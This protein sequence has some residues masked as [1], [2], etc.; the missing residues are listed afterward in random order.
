M[1]TDWFRTEFAAGALDDNEQRMKAPYDPNQPIETLYTQL[2]H[3]IGFADVAATPYTPNQIVTTSYNLVFKTGLYNDTCRE[4]RRRPTADKTWAH[5]QAEF[6]LLPKICENH[7]LP[8]NPRAI[9]ALTQPLK[10]TIRT[11]SKRT[12][13]SNKKRP[14]PW[15]T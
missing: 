1:G 11:L 3:A 13:G 6:P 12:G 14:Q 5:F 7:N 15:P 8:H 4:W 10:R 9:M 2:E